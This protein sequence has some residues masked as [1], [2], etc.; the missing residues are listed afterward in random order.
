MDLGK[1][2]G[3]LHKVQMLVN[4]TRKRVGQSSNYFF[5]RMDMLID[6]KTGIE[7]GF[8]SLYR[9]SD[10][11]VVFGISKDKVFLFETVRDEPI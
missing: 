11:D 4:V 8:G 9:Q 2:G 7:N 1:H 6:G 10:L 5:V 3:W